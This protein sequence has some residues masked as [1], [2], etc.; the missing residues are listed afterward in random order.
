MALARSVGRKA[1]LEMLLTGRFVS[2]SEAA[3]LGLINRAVPADELDGVVQ[4]AALAIAAKAPEAVALGKAA[5]NRQAGLPLAEAYAVA[6][7]AMAENLGFAS[8]K[9][10]IDGFLKR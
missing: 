9:S 2:A 8:A 5:F 6:S 1:A 4:D 7:R 3:G 10:G